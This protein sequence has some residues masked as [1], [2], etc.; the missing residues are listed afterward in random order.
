MFGSGDWTC[1]IAKWKGKMIGPWTGLD[2]TR[3]ATKPDS[4]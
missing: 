2:F 4:G 1:R 3:L